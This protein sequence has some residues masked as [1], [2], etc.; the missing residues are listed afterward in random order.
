MVF[1]MIL[2]FLPTCGLKDFKLQKCENTLI[3]YLRNKSDKYTV[4]L[5][6]DTNGHVPLYNWVEDQM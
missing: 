5:P 2:P 1:S 3:K 6:R 4:E